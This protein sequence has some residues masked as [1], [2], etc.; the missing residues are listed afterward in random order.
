MQNVVSTLEVLS[1]NLATQCVSFY[2]I[3]KTV[4]FLEPFLEGTSNFKIG[5]SQKKSKQEVW[6]HGVSK[7]RMRKFQEQSKKEV[8]FPGV[9]QKKS[10]RNSIGLGNPNGCN[11]ILWNFW[12]WSFI[13]SGV[14]KGKVTNLKFPGVFFKNVC[15]QPLPPCLFFSVTSHYTY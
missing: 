7:D 8:E 4:S 12:W 9:I 5:L 15:P 10:C 11:T 1:W 14:S 6:G 3:K 2:G 13:L